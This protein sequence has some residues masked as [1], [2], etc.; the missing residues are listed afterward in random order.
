MS[1]KARSGQKGKQRGKPKIQK[2]VELVRPKGSFAGG[3]QQKGHGM[4][5]KQLEVAKADTSIVMTAP[6]EAH[7]DRRTTR[8]GSAY[9][10]GVL[11]RPLQNTSALI[12]P[13]DSIYIKRDL[14][15]IGIL[16]S[17]MIAALVVLT[18]IIGVD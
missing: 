13:E 11:R 2:R 1:K 14:I 7:E 3:E 12:T 4:E 17:I 16:S 5:D 15:R 18:F 6:V 9:A 8:K 10:H